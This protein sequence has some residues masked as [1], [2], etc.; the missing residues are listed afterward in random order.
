MYILQRLFSSCSI[1]IFCFV[2]ISINSILKLYLIMFVA[3]NASLFNTL[4]SYYYT[5]RK[6]TL[7]NFIRILNSHITTD[8][9]IEIKLRLDLRAMTLLSLLTAAYVILQGVG[10]F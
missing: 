8:K 4:P 1:G 2:C 6:F 10:D 7:E 5:L 9:Y 3:Q